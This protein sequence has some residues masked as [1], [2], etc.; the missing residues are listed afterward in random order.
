LRRGLAADAVDDVELIVLS[1]ASATVTTRS[2][3]HARPVTPCDSPA[4]RTTDGAAAS[5][6]AASALDKVTASDLATSCTQ[7]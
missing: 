4:T 6:T 2:S 3:S 5:T 7:R 1:S